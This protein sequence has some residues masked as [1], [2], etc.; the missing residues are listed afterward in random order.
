MPSGRSFLKNT[1]LGSCSLWCTL[2]GDKCPLCVPQGPHG[3]GGWASNLQGVVLHRTTA[4][5]P[6]ML[7]SYD[8]SPFD[9][10][11]KL[12]APDRACNSMQTDTPELTCYY[13]RI[14]KGLYISRIPLQPAT[15]NTSQLPGPHQPAE[16]LY[17]ARSLV[18]CFGGVGF[19]VS[20]GSST[21]WPPPQPT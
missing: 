1:L 9:L 13:H 18:G 4:I 3:C 10:P 11:A 6:M 14:C 7:K 5:C 2:V 21:L 12:P 17:T 8:H 16:S 19:S 20:I 15:A